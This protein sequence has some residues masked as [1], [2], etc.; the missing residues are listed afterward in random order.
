MTDEQKLLESLEAEAEEER[1]Q[2]LADARAEAE[3]IVSK[4]RRE[5]E[6][7]I[8]GARRTGEKRG[9]VEVDRRIGLARQE[10]DLAVLEEKRRLLDEVRGGLASRIGELRRH[11]EYA[12]ALKRW[13]AEVIAGMGD[14]MSLQVHP[15]DVS[16]IQD[17]L[18]E[19]GLEAAVSGD[20]GITGGVRAVSADGRVSADNT[21]GSRL[22]RAREQLDEVLGR[23]LFAEAEVSSETD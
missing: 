2:L 23:A 11:A 20:A 22:E 18:S 1:E 13:T 21:L 17:M 14:G 15:E 16:V 3:A 8:E 5:A 4:A 6:Q 12:D 7:K 9:A 10:V 19:R